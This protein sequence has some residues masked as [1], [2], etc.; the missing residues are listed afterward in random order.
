MLLA[1]LGL[2]YGSEAS[3]YV[4]AQGDDGKRGDAGEAGIAHPPGMS[5]QTI[6]VGLCSALG[7]AFRSDY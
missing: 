4:N 3:G 1:R 2:L 5:N 6:E 7:E